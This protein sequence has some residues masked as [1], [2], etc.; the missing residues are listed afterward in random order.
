[1]DSTSWRIDWN[2]YNLWTFLTTTDAIFTVSRSNSHEVPMETLK[3]QN[4]TNV[5][6]RHSAFK[7]L[8]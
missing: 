2:P 5:H 1:M 8:A 6:D 3:D 4:G 7:T